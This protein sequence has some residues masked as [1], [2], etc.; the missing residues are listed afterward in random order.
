[1]ASTIL[2]RCW[3]HLSMTD[4]RLRQ[5]FPEPVLDAI[6]RSVSA[7]EQLHGGEIRVVIEADWP[8]MALL[9]GVTPRQ[10]ALEVF[11]LQSVWDTRQRNG[12]LIYLCLAERDVEI[13]ADR[14]LES[15]VS[16]DEWSAVCRQIET[17]C[18]AGRHEQAL[19]AAVAAVGQLLA[20]AYPQ[21]DRNEQRDRPVLL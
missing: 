11:A 1:M 7:S 20:R 2:R 5:T 16:P 18:A 3:R 19:C 12:V 4:W 13:V 8:L 14:G 6:T 17:A 9:R 21:A 15:V 10:R